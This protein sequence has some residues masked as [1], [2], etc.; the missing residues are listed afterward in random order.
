M[1]RHMAPN[2]RENQDQQKRIL[3]LGVGNI[4]LRDEGIGVKI[5]EKLKA[6]YEFSSNVEL[7]DGGTLGLRLLDPISQSDYLIVVDAVQNGQPPG[8]HYRL[9]P[10]ELEKRVTFKNS[11][12][13]LD[14]VESLAYSEI[15]GNRPYVVII[16]IE[17]ADIS[18]WGM[19]L[20]ETIQAQ[21]PE[22]SSRVLNEIE[23]AG[24][25]YAAKNRVEAAQ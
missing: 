20:T 12:H 23:A 4:L 3:V 15:L 1:Q 19:E 24:G 21:V 18:P 5:V 13:Q 17:P 25:K 7:M 2:E 10:E 9:P 22:I 8:T 6:E 16:G 14:L 11:L